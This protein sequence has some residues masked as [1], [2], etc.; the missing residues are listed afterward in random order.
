MESKSTVTNFQR[1]M[2]EEARAA[3]KPYTLIMLHHNP[4]LY[5]HTA[6]SLEE[7]NGLC[8]K[9]FDT[10]KTLELRGVSIAR[11]FGD[12]SFNDMRTT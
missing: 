12:R 8:P 4:M 6:K 1:K 9:Y 11:D 3:G 10:E 7:L 5:V 2:S